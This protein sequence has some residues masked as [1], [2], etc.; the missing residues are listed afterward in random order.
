MHSMFFFSFTHSSYVTLVMFFF[1][2][3]NF[4]C[5]HLRCVIYIT[6]AGLLPPSFD[7]V[8]N[9]IIIVSVLMTPFLDI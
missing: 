7:S 5:K 3:S 2:I 9:N 1:I 8:S 4:L 6:P